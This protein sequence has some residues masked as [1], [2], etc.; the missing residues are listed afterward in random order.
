MVARPTSTFTWGRGLEKHMVQGTLHS[1]MVGLIVLVLAE[2]QLQAWFAV[3]TD[4]EWRG[5]KDSNPRPT[6]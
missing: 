4:A 5:Q 1:A 6:A 3:Q 2:T